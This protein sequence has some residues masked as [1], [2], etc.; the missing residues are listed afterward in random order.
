MKSKRLSLTICAATALL[1]A[2]TASAACLTGARRPAFEDELEQTIQASGLS[3]NEAYDHAA[4]RLGYGWVGNPGDRSYEQLAQLIAG[5]LQ[6]AAGNVNGIDN[7]IAG[8][9]ED[10]KYANRTM[11]QLYGV[12]GAGNRKKIRR[13]GSI[14][15]IGQALGGPNVDLATVLR[16][17]WFNHFNVDG[18][19]GGWATID[20]QQTIRAEQC[21]S[22]ADMLTATAKHPAMLIYLNNRNSVKGDINENY[23]RE[24]LELMTFGED[25]SGPTYDQDDV[26]SASIALTGWTVN[27]GGNDPRFQFS[28]VNHDKQA[29]TL[30]GGANQVTLPSK[31][32]ASGVQRGELLLTHL[33]SRPKTRT[34]ICR[35]LVQRLVGKPVGAL[36]NQCASNA[37]WGSDGD[38]GAMYQTILTSPQMWAKAN[39]RKQ[40]KSPLELVVSIHRAIGESDITDSNLDRVSKG[41]FEMGQPVG[42]YGPPTGYPD[43]RNAWLSSASITYVMSFM[44]S[45]FDMKQVAVK[46]PGQAKKSGDALDQAVRDLVDGATNPELNDVVDDF[47]RGLGL[48]PTFPGAYA[49]TRLALREADRGNG[50]GPNAARPTRTLIQTLLSSPAFLRK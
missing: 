46:L 40:F 43:S 16:E 23:G 18:S 39:Y 19:A 11:K 31:N 2:D 9:D 22:F 3:V 6:G 12:F 8:S 25:P 10:F 35:K 33:A 47:I 26:V 20:Y 49:S 28:A 41:A 45:D 34:N 44:F 27:L 14:R 21:G 4:N 37:V 1:G 42:L 48:P 38:L 7:Q 13:M 36:T 29:L 50:T 17:F 5:R 15:T 30:F 32:G 24:L